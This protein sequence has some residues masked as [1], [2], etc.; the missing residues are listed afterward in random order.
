MSVVLR[1]AWR[2]ARRQRRRLF[3]CALSIVFGVA[4]LVAINSFADNLD[5]AIQKESKE[6]LGA[7]LQIASRTPFT[8]TAEAWF[9][10]LGGEQ[11]RETRFGSMAYFPGNGQSRLVQV[12]AL[13]GG[14]P[15]YGEFETH[16]AG[17]NPAQLDEP[18]AVVDPLLMAQYE[19]KP[20]DTLKL[21][22]T[23]FTIT[24]EIVQVPGEAAFA[25][26]FAPRI[27]IPMSQ[28][29]GTGLI[30]FGSIAFHRVYLANPTAGP[31]ESRKILKERFPDER[32]NIDTVKERK[33]D[34]GEPLD[35]LARFLGLV[36]FV[37]LLLGGV[38]IAGSVQVY[39]RDKRDSAAILRCIGASARVAFGVFL[40]QVL[41]VALLGA[42]LG[43]II[44]VFAQTMLPRLLADFLPFTIDTFLS[45]PNILIGLAYGALIAFLFALFPLLPLR[46]ISPLRAL[47]AEFDPPRRRDPLIVPLIL[48]IIA[49]LTG[50]C[51]AQAA[52]WYEGLWFAVGLGVALL[53]LGLGAQLLKMCLAKFARPKG[54]TMRQGLANLHRPNNRTVLL[55]VT[56]GMGAFLIFTLRMIESALLT[57]SELADTA[58]EPNLLLFD[59]Q[60]DQHEGVYDIIRAEGLDIMEESP[61]VTM[62]LLKVKGRSVADIKQD[63][64]NKIDG[65]ILNREWR[66]S[67]RNA[68]GPAEEI[69]EGEYVGDWPSMEEPVPISLEKDM[70]ADLGMQIDDTLTF[71]VQGIPMQVRVSSLR[72][73]DWTRMRPNFFATFPT[74]VLEEAPHWWIAVTRTPSVEV[75]ADLQRK[76]FE[77]YPNV[78]A[79]DLRI[80][81]AAL[82]KVLGRVNFA[83]RFM[84]LFT[85]LTG[86]VVMAATLITSRYQRVRESVLLRTLGA[87]GSQVR[88]IM[89][90]EY[91][92]LGALAGLLGVGTAL[93][94]GIALTHFAFNL[95]IGI[96]WGES[97]L[98]I[99]LTAS[100]TLL[101]GLA[102]SRGIASHPPLAILRQE[103]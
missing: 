7:D 70:A 88:A 38:G 35:N 82:Q 24:G 64:E 61:V 73:V 78:S 85:V 71:D 19:L 92:L 55:V 3:L 96:P 81:I 5:V 86:I 28:L 75:T 79:I 37:A 59:I 53:I 68:P 27:Y 48:L 93:A 57:Q 40:A 69:S 56:L 31:E 80:V 44:G 23:E 16:P 87:G 98:A 30:G 9:Q 15:W 76:I 21:G 90:V 84:A 103:A 77:A 26:I 50:F 66:S 10:E 49:L 12:R 34:I 74:G 60:P 11:A 20:G 102:N 4:A 36:G 91:A 18:V 94:A 62:R 72:E 41:A 14:F 47:R 39:L 58:N 42:T 54:F 32:L 89:A 8:D 33:E 67:Y 43:A 2:D 22:E 52:K 17:L 97:V 13:G 45:W 1:L 101:V 6:L 99:A 63:K 29:E 95:E 25:G 100:L 65:W 46:R 51:M 83:I